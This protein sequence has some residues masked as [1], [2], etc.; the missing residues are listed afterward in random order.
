MWSRLREHLGNSTH[1][2]ECA[3]QRLA[4]P[5]AGGSA[6]AHMRKYGIGVG[7]NTMFGLGMV[8]R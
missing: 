6:M 7:N 8:P 5:A 4:N 2:G 1:Q 3:A